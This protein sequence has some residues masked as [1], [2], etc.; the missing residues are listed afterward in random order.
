M[1]VKRGSLASLLLVLL[2]YSHAVALFA[3]DDKSTPVA[4]APAV[5]RDIHR[6]LDITGTVT[7]LRSSRLS[8]A[9]SGLV[10]DLYVD[11]GSRVKAQ[12]L[13]LELDPELAQLQL[14]S[15]MAQVEQADTALKDARRRLEE[16][17]RL[18]PQR[19]IAESVVRDLE[20]EVVGDEAALHQA[21]AESGYRR[22]IL[23]R[24]QL[25]APFDGVVSAKLTELGEWVDPGEAVL[26]LVAVDDV[27]LDFSV[28]EDYLADIRPDTPLTFSLNAD[29]GQV[30][31]GKVAT[32]VPVTDP[33]ARTFLLRARA[34]QPDQ[35]MLPGMSVRA[36]L[37]LATGRRGL[38]VPRDSILRFPD[39]RVV[40]WTIENGADGP[41]ARENTV[42]TGLAFDSLVEI[43]GGL[44]PDATVVVEGNE[45]LQDGQRV[46]VRS[47]KA[48]R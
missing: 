27:R 32:V 6:S 18:A 31:N 26:D 3:D 14:D 29:P 10:A 8:V 39:G 5:E 47:P 16:A 34:E 37:Q 1:V 12:E 40:V 17:R 41:I 21:Q 36:N 42:I 45:A 28:S 48:S 4:V 22:G 9:T 46:S 11:S 15:A 2:C 25:R 38:V 33:A 13:L 19:S 20:A 7:A 30:F 44:K 35:R 43:R 23:K 24:H